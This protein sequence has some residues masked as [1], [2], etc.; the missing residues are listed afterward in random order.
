MPG[1]ALV[2]DEEGQESVTGSV[3]R[4]KRRAPLSRPIKPPV[5]GWAQGQWQHPRGWGQA[6]GPRRGWVA[7]AGGSAPGRGGGWRR[8]QPGRHPSPAAAMLSPGSAWQQR[9]QG[10]H[11]R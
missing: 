2:P 5:S 1:Q 8:S 7:V 6:G 3:C 10:G 11:T 9:R 4:G